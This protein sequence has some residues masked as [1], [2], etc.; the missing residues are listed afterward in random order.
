[1][2]CSDNQL[3][4]EADVRLQHVSELALRCEQTETSGVL[5]D[6]LSWSL[7]TLMKILSG[8]VR[9]DI[10]FDVLL[11]LVPHSVEPEF[12]LFVLPCLRVINVN[13]VTPYPQ[14]EKHDLPFCLRRVRSVK[15][16]CTIL[17][18]GMKRVR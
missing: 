6:R 18:E 9:V 14:Q 8:K 12:I 17:F 2:S 13:A 7:I 1:M 3:F 15:D 5:V 16:Q 4:G 10:R 11:E